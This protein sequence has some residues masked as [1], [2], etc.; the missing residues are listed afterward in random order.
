MLQSKHNNKPKE[1]TMKYLLILAVLALAASLPCV[2]VDLT[3]VELSPDSAEALVKFEAEMQKESEA[4]LDKVSKLRDKYVKKMEY[5]AKRQK[6]IRVVMKIEATIKE[7]ED[8][9]PV[10]LFGKE[11][12]KAEDKK[13]TI[14]T[15][16]Y[17]DEKRRID[18]KKELTE[19]IKDNKIDMVMHHSVMG[20]NDPAEHAPKYAEVTYKYLGETTT[21]KVLE[22]ERF[23]AE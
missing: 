14:V 15:A 5:D 23:I 11:I 7:L 10:D 13:L 1:F 21:V 19:M 18:I 9:K 20:L 16:T 4:Y 8:R 22:K 6:D 17:G 3:D 2:E 12:V